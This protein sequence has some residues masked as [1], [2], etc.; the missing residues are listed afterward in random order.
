MNDTFTVHISSRSQTA[1]GSYR[2][3]ERYLLTI[4]QLWPFKWVLVLN[5]WCD[6]YDFWW[7]NHFIAA[8]ITPNGLTC[9]HL[10]QLEISS[11]QWQP[12]PLTDQNNRLH[13]AAINF[14]D[15]QCC[16]AAREGV[17]S[18]VCISKLLQPFTSSNRPRSFLFSHAHG[19]RC[20]SSQP[21]SVVICKYIAR[22]SKVP[23]VPL[24]Y[25]KPRGHRWSSSLS[26]LL[27]FQQG[28]GV[29]INKKK[30][31]HQ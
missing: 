23:C 20:C 12:D 4:S 24:T 3:S 8:G 5:E 31:T 15:S 28:R 16:R 25:F 11:Q 17:C 27:S 29:Q 1:T 10:S 9:E 21:A 2:H 30:E 26:L 7:M 18:A 19:D 6:P 13:G 22:R 14:P